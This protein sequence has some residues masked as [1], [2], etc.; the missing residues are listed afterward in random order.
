[1]TAAAVA[2]VIAERGALSLAQA[3]RCRVRYFSDGVALGNRAFVNE[4]FQRHRGNFGP[5]RKEGAR[6]LR[7]AAWGGLCSARDLRLAPIS[8]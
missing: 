6:P 4:V 2:Q 3:L 1:V 7:Y 8:G 5:K